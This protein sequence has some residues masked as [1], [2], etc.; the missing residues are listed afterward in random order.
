VSSEPDEPRDGDEPDGRDPHERE[1]DA[2][3]NEHNRDMN[4][5]R[6][7]LEQVRREL[8]YRKALWGFRL[9]YIGILS[10][11]GS[12]LVSCFDDS[13]APMAVVPIGLPLGIAGYVYGYYQ[14][15]NQLRAY[16]AAASDQIWHSRRDRKNLWQTAIFRDSFMGR[17]R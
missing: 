1:F 13:E 5:A 12:L 10:S 8:P 14:L 16:L 11:V 2:H 15:R 3:V 7:T 17:L 4:D 9:Y 6:D